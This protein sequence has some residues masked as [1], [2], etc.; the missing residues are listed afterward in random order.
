MNKG[1]R[2]LAGIFIL[3]GISL[4]GGASFAAEFEIL[5]RF[6]VDGYTVLR[7]SADVPGGSFA[8]GGSSL[9]VQY[10]NVG[11]GTDSP[12]GKIHV[13]TGAGS[14]SLFVSNSGLT[15]GNVGIGTTNPGAN[16][17]V[18]GGIK[19]SSV[20]HCA[21]DAAGTLRWYDGHISV[22]NGTDWRQ[23]DNQAPPTI[24]TISPD[25]GPVSG[26]TAITITG[27]GFVAGPAILIG[28]VTASAI[29]VVS[30]TQ[31]TATTP[32]SGTTGSKDVKITNPD[33]QNI[34]GAFTYNALPT[35]TAVSPDNGLYTGGT[36]ITIAGSGF[37]DGATVKINNV[38]ATGVAFISAT[39][40]TAA[41]PAGAIGTQDVKVT[42]PDGGFV[43]FSGG[44]R[45]NAA[46]T[47]TTIN[48]ASGPQSTTVVTITGTGF[49]SGVKVKFGTTEVTPSG[50]PTATEI[51]AAP[52]ASNTAGAQN[53]TVTNPDT[54]SAMQTNG[55]AYTV[56]AAGGTPSVSGSYRIHTFTGGGT[57]TPNTGGNIEVLVV[58][59]G[60][61]GGG[62]ITGGAGAGGL[63][64]RSAHPVIANTGYTVAVGA[65]GTG[66]A[67]GVSG[68]KGGNS[69]FDTLTA[70]GGG[71]TASDGSS[72]ANLQSGGSGGAS[73]NT[74]GA[75]TSG[76]GSNSGVGANSPAYPGGGGGGAGGAGVNGSQTNGGNG[77]PGSVYGISGTAAYYAGGGGGGIITWITPAPVIGQGGSGIGGAG[78]GTSDA[79]AGAANTGSGGG[80]GGYTAG[81]TY[82]KGGAGGSGIVIVR[83]PIAAGLTIP[84]VSSV[85]P[86]SG[87]GAGGTPITITGTGFAAS[88][89]VAIGNVT[90]TN[91][92]P[93]SNTEIRTT[94]PAS[95]NGGANDVTVTNNPDRS[96]G[97][98][99]GGFFYNPYAAGGT[100]VDNYYVHAFTA[101]GTSQL[102]FATGGSVDYL[103]VAGGGG[104]GGYYGAG[105]GAGGFR[106]GTI[107]VTAG[108]KTV[109]IG[110]GGI[111]GLVGGSVGTNGGD[112]KFDDITSL[113]G[114]YGGGNHSP[115]NTATYRGATGGSGGGSK[116]STYG[117]GGDG[118]PGQ[119]FAGGSG[120][121]GDVFCGGGGGAGGAGGAGLVDRPGDGGIG[122]SSSIR[123][124]SS[125]DY[126]GGGA[127]GGSS[128]ASASSHGGGAQNG[129]AGTSNTGGGG[130][131][132][133]PSNVSGGKGGSGIVIVRYLK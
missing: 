35:P 90:I 32:A 3:S 105:G 10:G 60:G 110:D 57:F 107:A 81:S 28:G 65:G 117:G 121:A 23:L 25:N 128:G 87:S 129:G 73:R 49:A 96:Y 42:N 22:C 112:S 116:G 93:F 8:V 131:G 108:A 13:S 41:V 91:V 40:I 132:G 89:D 100:I 82:T 33:G 37:V 9:V 83:Y 30:V 92:V 86:A 122:L 51:V 123:T 47:I 27:T 130:G 20:T 72:D 4:A 38:A 2:E 55:F 114:G 113:G 1:I 24:T 106:T 7:G 56:D 84:T 15:A 77:G 115:V 11:I 109:T 12:A 5:D 64:Y 74:A 45:Y 126:A 102:T 124:G 99:T 79:A 58:A 36:V 31:I 127:G 54:G 59:G 97:V 39:R 43:V 52:P 26:G 50:T 75:G 48:P 78:G 21:S 119:G 19:L 85:A 18:A 71:A 80:G 133:G 14:T 120:Y 88:V 125:A 29:T 70:S 68:T 104:G 95:A 98:K 62:G 101:V 69:V 66:G 46:P 67:S 16:L 63:I 34:T 53:V 103:V 118:T 61:G 94:T 6:S 111:G 76:Q 17:D 44:F